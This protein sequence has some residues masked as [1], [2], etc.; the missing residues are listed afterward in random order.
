MKRKK[1]TYPVSRITGG[2]PGNVEE[3]DLS[4]V[5]DHLVFQGAQ[6]AEGA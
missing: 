3:L 6:A 1:S 5:I 4:Q 2:V